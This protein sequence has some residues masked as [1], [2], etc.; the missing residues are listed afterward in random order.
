GSD[1]NIFAS[2]VWV[3][4][5]DGSGAKPLTQLTAANTSL[6]RWS[7][8]GGKIAFGSFRALDGSDA[9]STNFTDNIWVINA[10][11]SGVKPLTQLTAAAAS[12]DGPV[13][14][15]DGSQITFTGLRALDGS[16][17]VNPNFNQNIWVMNADGSNAKPLTQLTAPGVNNILPI[18][19]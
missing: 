8:D 19:P 4:N 15:P 5:A 7:P 6:V 16:D 14:S 10:D 11:G 2:N 13:W 17:N 18:H 1:N 12:S 3:I 9:P